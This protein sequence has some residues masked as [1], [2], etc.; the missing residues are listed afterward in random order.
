MKGSWV[1][2]KIWFFGHQHAF[3]EDIYP[4][5]NEKR[6]C[7]YATMESEFWDNSKYF[8][9]LVCFKYCYKHYTFTLHCNPVTC[10]IILYIMYYTYIYVCVYYTYIYNKHTYIYNIH[11]LYPCCYSYLTEEGFEIQMTK[12]LKVTQLT[13]VRPMVVCRK[14]A[15]AFSCFGESIL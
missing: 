14:H 13:S 8:A 12:H 2:L 5:S 4:R 6:I 7:V 11:I 3:F 10:T 1:S 15:R 9:V